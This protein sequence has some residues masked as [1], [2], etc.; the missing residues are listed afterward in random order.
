MLFEASLGDCVS[1]PSSVL[2]TAWLF[3]FLELGRERQLGGG[4]SI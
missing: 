4:E 3:E 2:L 1:T